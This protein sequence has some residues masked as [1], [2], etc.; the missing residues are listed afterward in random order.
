M[1]TLRFLFLDE[2]EE[3]NNEWRNKAQ[4]MNSHRSRYL[5]YTQRYV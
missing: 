4:N 5:P 1:T 2:A 3:F